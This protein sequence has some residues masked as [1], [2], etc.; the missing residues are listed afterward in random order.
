[1]NW[2][3]SVSVE[4]M[5]REERRGEGGGMEMK[6]KGPRYGLSGEPDPELGKF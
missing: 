1:M 3:N 6:Q 4:N 2:I 5:R